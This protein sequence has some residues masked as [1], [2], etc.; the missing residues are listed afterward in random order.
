MENQGKLSENSEWEIIDFDEETRNHFERIEDQL[1]DLNRGIQMYNTIVW[2]LLA[3]FTLV[4]ALL[5]IVATAELQVY[6]YE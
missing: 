1:Y 4:V 3:M 2:V 5:L 6:Y